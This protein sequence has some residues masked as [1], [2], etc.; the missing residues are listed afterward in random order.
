[1]AAIRAS[2]SGLIARPLASIFSLYAFRASEF[3]IRPFTVLERVH[4][5]A[6]SRSPVGSGNRYRS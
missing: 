1:V 2:R 6:P 5:T 4:G 3:W